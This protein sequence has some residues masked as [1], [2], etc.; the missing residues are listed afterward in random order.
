MPSKT[1]PSASKTNH[2][3]KKLTAC[4]VFNKCRIFAVMKALAKFIL[5]LLPAF[6]IVFSGA[7]ISIL[8]CSHTGKVSVAQIVGDVKDDC[9]EDLNDEC[10]DKKGCEDSSLADGCMQVNT[11]EFIPSIFDKGQQHDLKPLIADLWKP[12][13]SRVNLLSFFSEREHSDREIS[14]LPSAP[15]RTYLTLIRVLRI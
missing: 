6:L 3:K 8:Q 14:Y 7:G 5:T 10:H 12:F 4:C 9:H 11:L 15:P 1:N 2:D 13:E